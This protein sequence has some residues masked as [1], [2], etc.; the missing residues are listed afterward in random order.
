MS[1]L[2][3]TVQ[4]G[5]EAPRRL[6]TRFMARMLH[7]RSIRWKLAGIILLLTLFGLSVMFAGMTLNTR[8]Q[9]E[10]TLER[11]MSAIAEIIGNNSR[12]ALLF[13]DPA[14]AAEILASLRATPGIVQTILYD[15][16]DQRFAEYRNPST[17]TLPPLPTALSPMSDFS[18][19]HY[20]L[21]HDIKVND[22]RIG[23]LYL[24]SNLEA[25]GES[26]RNYIIVFVLLTALTI[27][28]TLILALPL[29]RV[30]TEPIAHLI[31]TAREISR[32]SDYSLRASKITDDELGILVDAFNSMLREIQNRDAELVASR[33]LLEQRV[34]ERT[35]EL[36]AANRELEAFS[37][38]V[39]HDLR[40]PLRAMDGFSRAVYEDYGPLLDERG[41]DYLQRVRAASQRMGHLIDDLLRLSRITRCDLRSQ[42]M[43]L[44]TLARELIAELRQRE[45]QRQVEVSIEPNIWVRADPDLM[46]VVLDNLLGNAWKFTHHNQQHPA[47]ITFG[48]LY[49]EGEIAY[50]VRDNG[51]GFD[52]AYAGKLFGAFQRLHTRDQFE[53]TGIGLATVQRVIHRHGG[54]VWA[55]A[56]VGQGAAFY[57]TL[58]L[59]V[60]RS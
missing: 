36:E 18:D 12:A 37:Y 42:D 50:Y 14:A 43:D 9:F 15:E 34:R 17:L 52:M 51:A 21:I 6:R 33:T 8:L 35:V 44:S 2:S 53:G 25:W 57:F 54:R 46:R 26:L 39:S 7:G 11:D 20:L 59:Q 38:S 32:R 40:A 58:P 31:G 41:K 13:D 10:H 27:G 24:V 5:L 48:R 56:Q 55:E 3:H 29:Q 1:A 30:I 28:L 49:E 16:D 19:D 4:Q 47:Q 23:R 45:P 22:R 60:E